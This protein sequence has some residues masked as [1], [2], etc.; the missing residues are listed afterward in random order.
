MTDNIMDSWL[1]GMGG[2]EFYRHLVFP[3][4]FPGREMR[5]ENWPQEDIDIYVK[6]L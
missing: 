4:L 2:S 6:G 5:L 3:D 1:N